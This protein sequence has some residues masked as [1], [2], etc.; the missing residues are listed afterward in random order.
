M[1]HHVQPPKILIYYF[2]K[3]NLNPILFDLTI[4]NF[5]HKKITFL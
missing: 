3:R 2:V 4:L 1:Y 5:T